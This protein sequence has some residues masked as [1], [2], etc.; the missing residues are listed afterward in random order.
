MTAPNPQHLKQGRKKDY[1][2]VFDHGFSYDFPW[3]GAFEE[4]AF[5]KEFCADIIPKYIVQ[6]RWFAGKSSKIKYVEVIDVF[7]VPSNLHRYY[8]VLIEVNFEEAFYQNYFIPISFMTK[9]E[10][11]GT[12]TLIAP[13]KFGEGAGYLV[14]A[15]HIEDFREMLFRK[16]VGAE[17]DGHPR[18]SFD[19]SDSI[20]GAAYKSSRFMSGEQ[21]NTSIIYNDDFVLK[22][23]RRIFIDP[24]P[25]FE[26]NKFLAE[27]TDFE[28][29]PPYRGSL[30][31]LFDQG[32][33]TLALMQLLV[34]N[35]GDAWS[36]F[37]KELKKSFELLEQRKVDI[38]RLPRN[39][40]F[41]RLAI[42][43]VPAEF[44]DWTGLQIFM[45]VKLLAERTAEMHSALGSSTTDTSFT[46]SSFNGDYEVWLK[47]KLTYQFQNRINTI[48]NNL[49][50]LEGEAKEMAQWFLKQKRAI[51]MRFLNFN[52][53]KFKGE[54]IR[55]HGDYHLGQVLDTEGD[56]CILDFEGEPESTIVDRKV[57]QPALKDVAGMFRSFHYAVYSAVLTN[58]K[59]QY[60]KEHLFEAAEKLYSYFVGVFLSAYMQ[61]IYSSGNLNLG[62]TKEREFILRYHLLEKAVYELGYELNSRPTWAI[63]PLR[64]IQSILNEA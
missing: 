31:M 21:S 35:K 11:D 58:D 26:V 32:T 34:P 9:A 14:D 46:P 16:I 39:R 19:I 4:E 13:A 43:E 64:G 40:M 36:L 44:I 55:I 53:T 42:Y 48:E 37:T 10:L 29:C 30:N 52:W 27:D 1:S 2:T 17:S 59:L 15:L 60:E 38:S 62:Y 61:R 57:K 25:D 22:I 54:R 18:L 56:F 23:Y 33:V 7:T 63:I 50:H 8:G 49:E 3:S 41:E 47:N 28:N 12:S 5:I 45:Q 51:R 20:R 6:K 24:N